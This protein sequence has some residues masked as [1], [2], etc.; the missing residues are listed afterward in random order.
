MI[1]IDC[2]EGDKDIKVIN[3]LLFQFWTV[4]DNFL[5]I[6][7]DSINNTRNLLILKNKIKQLVIKQ[8]KKELFDVMRH[9]WIE[10]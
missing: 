10:R 5:I 4:T 1:L 2:K 8:D 9:N 6:K 7:R 3:P